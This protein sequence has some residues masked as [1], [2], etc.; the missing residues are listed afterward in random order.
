MAYVQQYTTEDI[1]EATI[2]TGAVFVITIGLFAAVI[3]LFAVFVWAYNSVR[4]VMK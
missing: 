1:T 4:K 2:N 3:V